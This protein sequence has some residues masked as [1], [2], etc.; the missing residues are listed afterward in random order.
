MSGKPVDE[1]NTDRKP[2][3]GGRQ[4]NIEFQPKK[5]PGRLSNNERTNPITERESDR[6]EGRRKE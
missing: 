1:D 3:L 4:G 2:G 6:G 5:R